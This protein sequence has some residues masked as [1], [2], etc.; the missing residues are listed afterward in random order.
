MKDLREKIDNI[1]QELMELLN[2]RFKITKQIGLYK[3]IN[4]L[5]VFDKTRE[6]EILNKTSKYL[7]DEDIKQIYK[8]IF[9]Q[10][11]KYQDVKYGLIGKNVK[12]SLSKEI[13]TLLGISEYKLLS[14]NNLNIIDKINY[15]LLN[16]TNP[17]KKEALVKVN[18]CSNEV[19]FCNGCNTLIDDCCY[20]S[21][22]LALK[23]LFN[24]YR[25]DF[26]N[27][28]TIIIGNGATANTIS[29]LIDGEF[30]HL[31]RNI[32]SNNEDL[33]IN[34]DK[35][36]DYDYIINATPY[37][38]YPSLKTQPLFSL[39]RFKNVKKVFDVIYNPINTPL[40]LEAK[41]FNI[42]SYNG[43][44]M[45]VR[46]ANISYNLCFNNYDNKTNE[47]YDYLLKKQMN[48]VL[49]GMPYA[50]KTYLGERIAKRLNKKFID[51]DKELEKDNCDLNSLGILNYNEFRV[52]EHKMIKKIS[53]RTNCVISCGGGVVLNSKNIDLLQINGVIVFINQKLS[54][55]K[56]RINN[57]RPLIKDEESL[58]EMY[59]ER[60]TFY[61]KYCNI[62]INEDLLEKEE[63]YLIEDICH[64]INKYISN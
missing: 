52:F 37:G 23:E 25:F 22:Y 32:K 50:G 16:I 14:T 6:E 43:L 17:F 33:I 64:E 51:I 48:I 28:K 59:K 12:Y 54:T 26:K 20:N 56:Q 46:Q 7:Y 4:N 24:E 60:F 62:I 63:E 13:Y 44:K 2:E 31:V 3:Q 41:R 55:L 61:Q 30:I 49:I 39:N 35:Y 11:K 5:N 27:N 8:T 15:K 45:L 9:N 19:N 58:E 38:M 18:N 47:I 36:L 57:T 34:Y 29:K 42:E 10:N 53:K 1:D 40:I 21:D